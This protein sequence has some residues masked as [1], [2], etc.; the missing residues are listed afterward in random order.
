MNDLKQRLVLPRT[1][2]RG[3]ENAA[4]LRGEKRMLSLQVVS[5][6]P[7]ELIGKAKRYSDRPRRNEGVGD[8]APPGDIT[9]DTVPLCVL[10]Y[11]MPFIPMN[12]PVRRG[13]IVLRRILA[14]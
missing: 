10:A 8:V 9:G 4:L 6:S 12:A 14:P 11:K 2:M 1:T 5:V 7:I 13:R 3:Y